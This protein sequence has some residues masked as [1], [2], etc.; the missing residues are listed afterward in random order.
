MNNLL[1]LNNVFKKYDNFIALRDINLKVSYG[2]FLVLFGPSGSGKSTLLNLLGLIDNI[3]DG[4]L[5]FKGLNVKNYNKDQLSE[6]RLNNIGFIFQDFNLIETL[7]VEENILLSLWG[8]KDFNKHKEKL[9]FILKILDIDKIKDS[10][11]TM[12]S[13]GQK[14]RVAIAR[15]FIKNPDLIVADEPTA[16]LDS[17]NALNILDYMK[18]LSEELNTTIIVSTH[19]NKIIER[20]SN[21]IMLVDGSLNYE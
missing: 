20:I 16:N 7:N 9:N 2:E 19:D 8:H 18:K 10:Y 4:S 12:I 17:K 6:I 15:A 3:D 5:L 1:E 21:K 11:P 13:G 14:Q